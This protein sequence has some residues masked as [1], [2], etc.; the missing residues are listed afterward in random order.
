MA[1][2]IV[3]QSLDQIAEP[4]REH[5]VQRDGRYVLDATPHEGLAIEDVTGLKNSL[6]AARGE[7]D[8]L[9]SSL[10][11]FKDLDPE[12]ARTAL[13]KMQE[14]QS[15]NPDKQ[16]EE[17]IQAKLDQMRK[18]HQ[19]ELEKATGKTGE[20]TK[21]LEQLM[22]V[23]AASEALQKN[24]GNIAL[25]LPHV[26]SQVRMRQTENGMI[27]EVVDAQ[28]NPRVGD[29]QGNP[30]TIPQLV[31]EMRNSTDFAPAFAG[32]GSSG[33]GN[34]GSTGGGASTR[35]AP[36]GKL[37]IDASDQAAINANWEKLASGEAEVVTTS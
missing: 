1:L 12:A 17:K 35:S 8:Q 22:V 2:P 36:G 30:M 25:L 16:V 33:S 29:S 26:R 34:K 9:K 10:A 18:L 20:L 37:L 27:C 5:Y 6:A 32:T 7:R 28:G 31:E 24:G 4:L 15:W 14:M 13:Q 19:Q 23:N 3:I 11:Q 21:Q